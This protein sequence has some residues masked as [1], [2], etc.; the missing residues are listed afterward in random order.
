METVIT[1]SGPGCP[2]PLCGVQLTAS[3]AA[4]FVYGS[5][6]GYEMVPDA[7]HLLLIAAGVSDVTANMI[8]S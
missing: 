2:V 7:P 3:R 4:M 1:I 6:R 8:S 5:D